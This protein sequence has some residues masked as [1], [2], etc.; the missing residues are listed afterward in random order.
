[1]NTIHILG[2][3]GFI[4]QAI[5]S[6]TDMHDIHCWSH[7]NTDLE[8]HFDLYDPSTWS[9]FL[10]KK[11]SHVILLSWPGL[12]N[13]QEP[14]HIV[15]NMP[16]CVQLV[17][18][19]VASGL[20]RL[21]IAG[22]CYEY[23]LKNGPLK[24]TD[25]TAPINCYAI[26]KN[27]LRQAIASRYKNNEFTF[28]WLRIFYPYGDGQNPNSLLPSLQS[29]I[30]RKEIVFPMSSGRQLRD[31]V[32]V[33]DIARQL[34]LLATHPDASGVYNG[35]SGQARSLRE[36]VEARI[37][38]LKAEINIKLGVYPDREDEPVA[39]WADMTRMNALMQSQLQSQ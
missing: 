35:G 8:H 15:R 27:S 25:S 12:P 19:L 24:E 18:R 3:Q 26:A 29:A 32:P 37:H 28:C 38:E 30:E 5:Q 4:G 31:F 16:L 14:F 34:L 17:E 36:I 39:F 23:G 9:S 10:E 7:L 11:P 1:M 22:T 33:Q 13:Y 2:S 21:V 6:E 20:K